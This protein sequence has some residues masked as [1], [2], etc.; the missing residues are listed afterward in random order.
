MQALDAHR[1]RTESKHTKQ[2]RKTRTVEERD[3]DELAPG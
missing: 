3:E 1:S 2:V